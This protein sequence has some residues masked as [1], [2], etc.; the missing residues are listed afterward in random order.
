[1]RLGFQ[2][3]FHTLLVSHYYPFHHLSFPFELYIST[4]IN[5]V[6][7]VASFL[8]DSIYPRPENEYRFESNIFN[9]SSEWNM[10][11]FKP[12]LACFENIRWINGVGGT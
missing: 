9:L 12:W 1:M 8:T 7:N 4:T 10:Y 6:T 11:T 5:L 3:C 2:P